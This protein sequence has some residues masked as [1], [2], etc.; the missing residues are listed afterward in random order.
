MAH[1]QGMDAADKRARV[2]R[3]AQE[4]GQTCT[5]VE[6]HLGFFS[7]L[8]LRDSCARILRPACTPFVISVSSYFRVTFQA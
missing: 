4:E 2:L 7:P 8:I 5:V 6:K 1:L 3:L